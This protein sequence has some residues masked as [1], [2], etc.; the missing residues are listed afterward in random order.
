VERNVLISVGVAVIALIIS[1]ASIVAVI[2]LNSQIAAMNAQLAEFSDAINT[3]ESD[4]ATLKGETAERE[5]SEALKKAII[6]EGASVAIMSWTYGGLW[7]AKFKDVFRDYTLRKYGVPI[8][9]TWMEHYIEHIDELQL[10][11]KNLSYICDVIEAEEDS[12]FAESKLG[13]FDRIDKPEYTDMGVL[14]TFQTIPDYQKV[15]YAGG[16]WMGVAAQGFEWLG[17]IVRQDIVDPAKI[18]SWID[19]SKS[20]FKGRVITYTPAEVRGQ[21]I[22]L[23]LTKALVDQGLISG[24][25]ETPF[26]TDET[27]LL[28]AM[29]WYKENI[30][31]NIH[32]YVGTGEM[33]TLMQSGD[34]W[35]CCTWG[36]YSR[37]IAGAEW[38]YADKLVKVIYP[39]VK[40][41][42]MDRTFLA[43]ADGAAHPICAR[44]LVDWMT[45]I[46]FQL[47]GWYKESPDKTAV[48]RFGI[49]ERQ[50]LVTCTGGIN[51]EYKDLMPDWAAE[52][53]P[54]DP[55]EHAFT[56]DWDWYFAIREWIWDNFQTV[57]LV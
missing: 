48:N 18:S 51:P 41:F 54:S 1:I 31:P 50:F 39:G 8:D 5:K 20:E 9:L 29:Q 56:M 3:L 16:G 38:A 2:P 12:W 52:F 7:E 55:M 26:R 49:T 33:R 34:A 30:Q 6:D 32:S 11:G 40:I 24:S 53:Y 15:P 36:V 22:F 10:A 45:S 44:I 35:I 28:N 19:L 42:P 27:T 47:C 43:V 4:V 13:W 57:V 21:M 25:Y 23:G 46:E 17:I 37:E 14:D